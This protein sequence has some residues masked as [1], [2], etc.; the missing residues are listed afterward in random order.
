MTGTARQATA[1]LVLLAAAAPASAKTPPPPYPRYSSILAAERFAARRAGHV[2]FAVM[3][4]DRRIRGLNVD[5]RE[6]SASVVKAML[7][8]DFLRHHRHPTAAQRA[9]LSSMIR[10]SDNTAAEAIYSSVGARGLAEVGR[11][12]GMRHLLVGV[13]LFDTGITPSDQVRFFYDLG[14]VVPAPLLIWAKTLLRTVVAWQSW[15]IPPAAR[16]RHWTVFFKGG[17]RGGLTH[18]SAQMLYGPRRTKIAISVLTRFSPSMVYAEQTIQGIAQ[19]LLRR[20]P[21]DGHG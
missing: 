18:Q 21:V 10:V 15:G 4:T 5:D 6:P 11:L 3:R 8:A 19:R 1:A 12:V 7:L 16:P 9:T 2:A 17:W 13:P 20:Y 14:R